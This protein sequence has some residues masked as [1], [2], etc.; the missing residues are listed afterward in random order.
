MFNNRSFYEVLGI[1]RDAGLEE[2]KHAYRLLS[3]K[4]HPDRAG[5]EYEKQFR[6]ITEAYTIL[7]NE[8]CRKR[9]DETGCT[10]DP[11][12]FIKEIALQLLKDWFKNILS[13]S[14]ISPLLH[15]NFIDTLRQ[16]ARSRSATAL[17][18]KSKASFREIQLKMI[19]QRIKCNN[20][21][22]ILDQILDE[23][24]ANCNYIIAQSDLQLKIN[25]YIEQLLDEYILN[26]I[27]LLGVKNDR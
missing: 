11:N 18:D 6:E 17:K 14:D 3:M 19:K 25:S 21:I 7:S 12:Q 4:F 1:S 23:E 20:V 26:P 22:N 13:Q 15:I 24:I 16:A 10:D 27:N 5:K 8:E 9:Y 2:V